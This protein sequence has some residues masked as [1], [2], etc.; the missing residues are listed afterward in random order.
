[1]LLGDSA[2]M[3]DRLFKGT[4]N[5]PSSIARPGASPPSCALLLLGRRD[6][7]QE[8]RSHHD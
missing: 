3:A 2:L 8:A 7:P 1:V 6:R 4:D 5:L